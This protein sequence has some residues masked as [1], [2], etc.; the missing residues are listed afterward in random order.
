[1]KFKA[2]TYNIFC[3]ERLLFNDAQKER[4]SAIPKA[5]N[6]YDNDI[7]CILVQENFWEKSEKILDREMEKYGFIYKSEKVG[8]N[9]WC[10]CR[11]FC[12]KIED[13]GVKTYSKHPKT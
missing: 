6:K 4:C 3:R 5:L 8:A 1:M 9:H 2:I 7:D 12:G 13:G 11:C 10:K